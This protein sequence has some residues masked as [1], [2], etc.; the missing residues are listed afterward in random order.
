MGN[1][2]NLE[3]LSAQPQAGGSVSPSKTRN[4]LS[5]LRRQRGNL[6]GRLTNFM[7]YLDSFKIVQPSKLQMREIGFRMQAAQDN[8]KSFN[9][10]QSEIEL[11]SPE[12]DV[13]SNIAYVEMFE[14]LYFSA[15]ATAESL[16]ESEETGDSSNQAKTNSGS[17]DTSRANVKLP[18]IKLPSFDGSY[19]H[20]LEY[21]NSYVSM[22][23]KRTDLDAIQKFHYLRS[24]LSGSALQVIIALEFT[25]SN[26][27][28]A[29]ELLENRFHNTRLLVHNHIKSL[30][31]LS[32]LKQESPSQIRKLIDTVLRNLRAL[33]TLDEPT[34]S[35][36]T[37]IIYLIA[38]KLDSSTE[39]DWESHKGSLVSSDPS[40]RLKL[41]D[42][43][44]FLR[45]KA[46]MLEMINASH[47]TNKLQSKST[48]NEKTVT[49]HKSNTPV[50]SFVSTSNTGLKGKSS[51][52]KRGS[53]CPFC[54]GNH[55]LYTC[56]YFLNLS[57][58]DRSKFVDE[59]Q[60]CRNC[61]RSGHSITE[62]VFGP[63]KQCQGK[64]NSLLHQTTPANSS[65]IACVRADHPADPSI[66]AASTAL[67]VSLDTCNT[68]TLRRLDSKETEG[69]LQ[70][71]LLCTALV[72]ILG[73]ND[74]WVTAR[75]L[76]DNGSQHCFI[77]EKLQNQINAPL[78][79]STFQISGV[80]QSVT[81]S[82]YSCDITIRS[83]LNDYSVRAQCIVLQ[84][85]TSG[86]PT[87]N[88]DPKL[89]RIPNDVQLADPTFHTQ[90]E[91]DLLIGAD[92]FWDLLDDNRIRLANGPFLQGSRLGFLISG[93]VYENNKK[94]RINQINVQSVQC[95]YTQALDEQLKRFWEVEEIPQLGR[96]LTN[97]ECLCEEQ[98]VNTTKRLADGRFSVR[99]PLKE[100]TEALGDS[101]TT[102]KN[103][104]LSLERKLERSPDY[105]R[106]YGEFMREYEDL[107][108]MTRISEPEKPNYFLCHHG[109]LKQDRST[110]KL[111]VVFNGSVPTTS[112]KS[113]NDIQLP[114]PALQNDIFAILLRFRQY[115]YVA[116]ADVEK[117]FRQVLIQ[118]DQRSLQLIL[119]REKPIDPLCVY[120]LN[121]VT[122]GTA[123]APYLS[124]RCIRQLALE[125]E[126]DVISR[127]IKED[128][129]VD[130]LITGDDDYQNLLDICDRIKQI[131]QSGCFPLRKWTFNSD[132]TRC[133]STEMFNGEHTQ[134]KT[135]GIGWHNDS[136][137][138]HFTTKID[139]NQDESKLTKRVMLSIISQIYDPLGLLS[140]A[141][142]IAKVLLQKLWLSKLEWDTV[143]PPE[144]AT[145]WNNF[146]STLQC[147]HE[148]KIPRRVTSDNV[149]H[150]ELHIFSD[151]SQN[152]FGACAYIRS[153]NDDSSVNVRLLCAKTKVCPLKS[154]SI[155]KL[156]LCAAY[157]GAKL[158]KKIIDSLRLTFTNTFF[159][160]DSTIVMGW[161]RM[162]PHLLKTFVQTRVTKINE[163]TG[164]AAWLHVASKDN[165]ADLL[166][167]GLN[168]DLLI[169]CTLW[170]NGPSYLQT[171]DFQVS[172][173]NRDN[174]VDLN[175]LPEL[176]KQTFTFACAPP[177]N[178]FP[179]DRYSSFNRMIHVGAYV[180]RFISNVRK[181]S[182]ERKTKETGSLTVDE[183]TASKFMLVRCAQIESFPDV[184]NK[185]ANN[186]SIKSNKAE[187]CRLSSLNLF[188]DD[189][190]VIRVGGRLF[191][192]SSFTYDKKHPILLCNKHHFTTLLVRHE[193]R[194]LL[195]AG[196]QL[197][198]S[199]IRECWW[200][201]RSRNIV[202]KIV[203]DCILCTRIKGKT[204]TPIM[205]NLP[206][207]RLDAC[208]PFTRTG[209][210]YAGPMFIL[211]R[212]GRGAQ[213]TKAY[214][215]LFICFITRSVHL[216]LVT[217]L[218]TADY[219][220]ALKRFISRRGKPDAIFSDNGKNFVG[221]EKELPVFLNQNSKQII[222]FAAN[223]G[224]K[225]HFIP[226]YSPHFGG[227]WES[228]IRSS[229]FILK[230]VVG[231]A[232]L[233]YEEFSTVLTQ[234]EAILNSRPMSPLSSD[235][236]DLTPLT[237]GHFLIG[238]PLTAP[239][240]ED[241]SA[242]TTSRL[243]RYQHVEQLRQHFWQRWARE[244]VSELQIRTKWKTNKDDIAM[245]TLV[246]IKD[247][248]LPPLKWRLG[249]IV[250]TFPGT[251]GVSRVADIHTATGTIRR[252]FS[253][254]CPLPVRNE[255]H[256][257]D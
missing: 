67:H 42:L 46:D 19:D 59:K 14:S 193:H 110:S 49:S 228:G 66:V 150:T 76:L 133:T 174:S 224:I 175:D 1:E 98:F 196:P 244:Y 192:A 57:V 68:Q 2:D 181:G 58:R 4:D 97:D 134:N 52:N 254:I 47:H 34:E 132:V 206:A 197:L 236:T 35:W 230:R 100:S 226:P 142:I 256:N 112:R 210:D 184:Y 82:N 50:H 151:A 173:E 167:R 51:N 161:V 237:P 31:S 160:T 171:N 7:K 9:K 212:K 137:E 21:K 87:T 20:W 213:L 86:L 61:L 242:A 231:N 140:P 81:H 208:F 84:R 111:R 53:T 257:T 183:L 10:I 232:R 147:L 75:A 120:Q 77:S 204:L 102:A 158:Y 90:S 164:E 88:I 169:N 227:L 101:Y 155:P 240:S 78:I 29:W 23:H 131:L 163:L 188:M 156:E 94:M 216:E 108:H 176:K 63:C 250:K 122:Y 123:S 246:L 201:L 107:G 223:D 185:L 119:W 245:D 229:K 177:N 170:W 105:K 17:S 191:N 124:M 115:K 139:S 215:C 43:L 211:N 13:A 172:S 233:T 103:R 180:L 186:L 189:K 16:I 129:F 89:I 182:S 149:Q 38:S 234:I 48:V 220:L 200:P 44:S 203:R 148:L 113:L 252:A 99:I 146:I 194:R 241:L 159:W 28:N 62:C 248:H 202:R 255:N 125:C 96:T 190:R 239:A 12:S 15:L 32:N 153:Y 141:V 71:V 114:G 130:D 18:E 30:F 74:Q 214:V 64:H 95:N 11:Y 72:D 247:D 217:S 93:P 45:N 154:L 117:M 162:S 26:Y 24:S 33:K 69:S 143:V 126:D 92:L 179:F 127:V 195:H 5:D 27:L 235:P 249:R 253:K 79:Q 118:S 80:A 121:T 128:F 144:I 222:D 104:F 145:T 219:L 22:I 165:P 166:S 73:D 8:F 36:D 56:S 41:E 37:L 109:V 251:D 85:I 39:R 205:G 70:S 243:D 221:A 225:F 238:R 116:C 3:V 209:V 187:M 40:K 168:L 54:S 60:V 135:L 138:L 83:K 55:A 157:V 136:D 218:S 198:L 25:A 199:S 152:A 207:E 106:M 91:I 6:K 65:H 178:L